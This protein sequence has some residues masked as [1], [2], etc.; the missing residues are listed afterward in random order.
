[1]LNIKK[2]QQQKKTLPK[3]QNFTIILTTLV[4]PHQEY[5]WILGRKSGGLFQRSCRL[6]LLPPYAKIWNLK[7]HKSFNNFVRDRP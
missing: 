2:E 3:I 6:R 1:M 5:K 4:D 7:F